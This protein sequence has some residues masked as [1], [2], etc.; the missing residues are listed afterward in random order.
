MRKA[1]SCA[2]RH[3][4]VQ[5]VAGIPARATV[6][7]A[8]IEAVDPFS[9]T[10]PNI[11]QI[12]AGR[13]PHKVVVDELPSPIDG[14]DDATMAAVISLPG[15]LPLEHPIFVERP[16]HHVHLVVAVAKER[17]AGDACR[18]PSRDGVRNADRPRICYRIVSLDSIIFIARMAHAEHDHLPVRHSL[19]RRIAGAGTIGLRGPRIL[20]LADEI[21]A[22][23]HPG[24]CYSLPVDSDCSRRTRARR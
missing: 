4:D 17:A 19:H 10:V 14:I 1:R 9:D 11:R 20:C 2:G 6:D 21:G 15:S 23:W 5:I 12:V 22:G 3:E 24:W 8:E 18:S 16:Q 13:L 7:D